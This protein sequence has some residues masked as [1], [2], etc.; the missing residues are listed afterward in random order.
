M[1]IVLGTSDGDI[2][3]DDNLKMSRLLANKSIN[4]WYDEKPWA[5][6]DWPLW[7][8]MFSEYVRKMPLHI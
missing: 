8:L 1:N 5:S 3:R 6:H 2:C 7:K 4:H